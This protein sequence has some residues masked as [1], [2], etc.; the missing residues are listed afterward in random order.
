M[1]SAQH[2]SPE[3]PPPP[4]GWRRYFDLF[5]NEVL[6][7]AF[8][9]LL[10][11]AVLAITFS[12]VGS[13]FGVPNL[14]R[15]VQNHHEQVW[16]WTTLNSPTLWSHALMSF[17]AGL[18][19]LV[20]LF[21]WFYR[22]DEHRQLHI[23][24]LWVWVVLCSMSV[25]IYAILAY[26]WFHADGS[27]LLPGEMVRA[28]IGTLLGIAGFWIALMVSLAWLNWFN[29]SYEQEEQEED[30]T[31]NVLSRLLRVILRLT[32]I[33]ANGIRRGIRLI[34]SEPRD[35]ALTLFYAPLMVVLIVIL[36]FERLLPGVAL[37]GL[38]LIV[39][40][41]L[42]WMRS[43]SPPA[44]LLCIL[45]IGYFFY[46][47]FDQ[48]NTDGF[49][50]TFDG[51]HG[52]SGDLYEQSLANLYDVESI[53]GADAQNLAQ[54]CGASQIGGGDVDVSR[55]MNNWLEHAK[56]VQG[57]EKPKLVIVAT[58]GGAYRA[59]FWTAIILDELIKHDA[60]GPLKGLASSV[61]F[62]T[63]ASGGMVAGAYFSAMAKPAGWRDSQ[64]E[65][66]SILAQL[67]A[68]IIAAQRPHPTRPSSTKKYYHVVSDPFDRDSLSSV[69]R[70]MIRRDLPS[71]FKPGREPT[72]RG[73]VLEKHWG[74]VDKPFADFRAGEEAGW[75]PSILFTPMLVESSKPL[76]IT[77]LY[78]GSLPAVDAGEM[79][80]FFG[81]YPCARS[82]FSMATAVRMSATFPY[83]SPALSLPAQPRQ[84][85]VDAGYYDNYGVSLVNAVLASDGENC[86][87][88][89]ESI[90]E[91]IFDVE[92]EQALR[93]GEGIDCSINPQ[94][95]SR[96]VRLPFCMSEWLREKTSGILLLE[97]RAFA[98][99]TK[100]EPTGHCGN[101]AKSRELDKGGPLEFFTSPIEA[102]IGARGKSMVFRNEQALRQYEQRVDSVPIY[103]LVLSN[104]LPIG[105]NW[106]VP[107]DELEQMRAHFAE[108]W[109]SVPQFPWIAKVASDEFSALNLTAQDWLARVWS[110][111]I[112]VAR[113]HLPNSTVCKR[114]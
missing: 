45:A 5:A 59:S 17:S 16:A 91:P 80:E 70:Q 61:R 13:S 48:R 36:T 107:D 41:G 19:A 99:G 68:D 95:S 24:S 27:S 85:V 97:I 39:F 105:M 64:G 106:I 50:L 2:K 110:A 62:V 49:K 75:R 14:F 9:S 18:V 21:D 43:I 78:M 86:F 66:R 55:A 109:C 92:C 1:S 35:V 29:A 28:G 23:A 103:R 104:C 7:R 114:T 73:K 88:Q 25:V 3:D 74:T 57:L 12:G 30:Q 63:G 60:Q 44:R 32:R 56:R 96:E 82:S 58:S 6:P 90:E 65:T 37:V 33:L 34:S 83:I 15:D 40:L 8:S 84:R 72:D 113:A 51:I 26:L 52:P 71:L 10:L 98:L 47:A 54:A 11:L 22:E 42:R 102:I 20:P 53:S 100:A 87:R 77:N 93:R 108:L 94:D 111:E 46:S 4:T 101:A 76:L 89:F 81:V 31:T 69:A 112:G 67:E 79:I 38:I